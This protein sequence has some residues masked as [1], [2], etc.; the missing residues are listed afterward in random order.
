MLTVK[1]TGISSFSNT[2]TSGNPLKTVKYNFRYVQNNYQDH[3]DWKKQFSRWFVLACWCC[4]KQ[5]PQAYKKHLEN[6]LMILYAI[7]LYC[8]YSCC[9]LFDFDN[10]V[11]GTTKKL[12]QC[13]V[14]I[15]VM[16]CFFTG[17][18]FIFGFLQPLLINQSII[19]FLNILNCC[20]FTTIS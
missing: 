11:S 6:A 14:N 13:K 9:L 12:V 15:A 8:L 20:D 10:G 3:F 1:Q 2:P 5:H 19:F 18:F 7:M 4:I 16:E 17:W